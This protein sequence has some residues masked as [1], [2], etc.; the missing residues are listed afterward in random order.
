MTSPASEPIAIVGLACRYPDS[1]SPVEFWENILARR[2]QFRALPPQ[3]LSLEHYYHPD[4]AEPD[5]TYGRKAAVIDGFEFDWASRR[6][7][8]STFLATDIAHWLA[9][10]TAIGAVADAGYTRETIP[11]AATGVIV[12]NS[13]TGEQSR[14]GTMRLRWPYVRRAFLAA[15]KS[16]GLGAEE[17]ERLE[18]AMAHHFKSVFP[19]ANEDM[20]A[21]GLSNTISGRICNFLNLDGGGYTVDGACSSSLLAI[22]IAASGL[23]NRE[24]DLALAGGVDISL[25]SFEL[26]GF[27]K[28]RAL[29]ATDM[30]VYDR[31]GSGFI[32]GEGCGFIV[33]KR[34]SDARRNGDYVY[35]LLQGWGISSDGA[36]TG[37]TAP[38]ADGQKKALLRAYRRA[39]Y[40]IRDLD[41]VEGHGTATPVGDRT[42]LDALSQALGRNGQRGKNPNAKRNGCGITSLKSIVGHTKA[43]AGIG[44]MI[45]TILA[46]NRRVLPPTAACHTPHALFDTDAAGLYPIR[47]GDIRPAGDTIRAG[48]SAMGFGG[49]NC[50]ITV[51]SCDP[52]RPQLHPSVEERAL[53]VSNQDTE[54]FVLA[55]ASWGD[56]KEKAAALQV[57][58]GGISHA[59][60]VDLAA[61]LG[62]E[63]DGPAEYRAALIADQPDQ[64]ANNLAQL[65]NLLNTPPADG[66]CH[67]TPD[68]QLWLGRPV[69]SPRFGM[70]FPGQGSQQLN[71]ARTLTQRYPWARKIVELADQCMAEMGRPPVGPSIF[72]SLDRAKR[73]AA[74]ASPPADLSRTDMAQPAI[75]TA[76]V[77]WLTYLNNLG[78]RAHAVGGHSLGELTAFHAAGVLD[79]RAVIRLAAF[80]GTA[81]ASGRA[82]SG[83]MISL[84]CTREEAQ[85]IVQQ[86]TG[87]LVL[88]NLN[89]PRQMVLSGDAGAVARAAELAAARE[90]RTR[91]LPVSGAFHSRLAAGAA[92]TLRHYPPLATTMPAP[93][94]ALFS[95]M[96][97]ARLEAGV[98]LADHFS[99][100]MLA[101]VDFM[102]L[103]A[104]MSEACDLLFEVGPGRIL[105]GLVRDNA[106]ARATPICLPVESSPSRDRDLNTLI[107]AAFTH[108]ADINWDAL[109][110]KRM[111]RP[112][113]SPSKKQFII[114]PCEKP[115]GDE[116]PV[117]RAA[118]A[119]LSDLPGIP[120]DTLKNY[121]KTRGAFL[122]DVIRADL[123]HGF[124]ASVPAAPGGESPPAPPPVLPPAGSPVRGGSKAAPPSG[125]DSESPLDSV[126]FGLIEK[127]TGFPRES[128]D[129]EMRLLDDLNLDSIK[130]GDLLA[131]AARAMGRAGQLEPMDLANATL[132]EIRDVLARPPE[133]VATMPRILETLKTTVETVTGYDAAALDP[134]A[135]VEDDLNI[136]PE[137]LEKVIRQA[138]AEL[139]IDAQVDLE[140]LLG[141]SLVHIAQILERVSME[142]MARRAELA[143]G[144]ASDWVREFE[145]ERVEAPLGPPSPVAGRRR[146]DNWQFGRVLLVHTPDNDELVDRMQK[147]LLGLGAQ[148]DATSFETARD[149]QTT[150]NGAY[151]HLLA[152]LPR[153][154]DEADL[155][156]MAFQGMV[157]R[158]SAVATPPPASQSL[159]RRTTVAYLQFGGGYFGDHPDH[160]H[161][162]RCGAV[163][164]ASSLHHERQDL[165]VRVLDFSTAIDEETVSELAIRELNTP[166][167][168]VAAGFDHERK[169]RVSR[170]R[171]S[172]PATW[173]P[174]PIS[175]SPADVILV[176]GGAKGITAACALGLAA[177]TN[178]RM[179]LLGRTEMP[180]GRPG[181]PAGT[182]IA[183]TLRKFE[184]RGRVARYYT[185]DVVDRGSLEDAIH[186]IEADLG[187]ITGVIH[188]AG[189]NQPRPI[190]DVSRDMALK[191]IAPKLAGLWN[192]IGAL[193]HAPLKLAVGMSSIIGITGMPG[194][195][196]YGFSNEALNVILHRWRKERPGLHT[197]AV[198]YSIWRDEG[199]GARMG[200]VAQLKRMGTDAI[201]SRD[202][203]E[204]FV[205]LVQK[206]PGTQQVIVTARL[207]GL[208]TW[209]PRALPQTI[210]GRYLETLVQGTP[211]VE[212]VFRTHL[213]LDR[214]PY[215]REHL[216]NGTYLLPTVFGLEAMAQAAAHACGLPV[217]GRIRIEDIQLERPI[218]VDAETGA[219][220]II[221][222]VVGEAST[223]SAIRRIRTG[224]SKYQTGMAGDYFSAVF[225]LGLTEPAESGTPEPAEEAAA[226][227]GLDPAVDLY[228]GKLLFQG[229]MF[230]RIERIFSIETH[231]TAGGRACGRARLT[232]RID[233]REENSATAFPADTHRELLLGD[234]FFR[235]SLLQ[236]A[237]LLVPEKTCLPVRIGRLDI[238]PDTEIIHD[239]RTAARVS[240]QLENLPENT[241][242]EEIDYTLTAVDDDGRVIEKLAGYTLKILKEND[243]FPRAADLVDPEERDNRLLMNALE[244]P[245]QA[246][247]IDVPVA[248]LCPMPGIHALPRPA[249]HCKE[250]P[251]IARTLRVAVPDAFIS[252]K[253]SDM[254]IQWRE[255]GK[256]VAAGLQEHGWDLSLSHDER[257]CLCVA[258]NGPQ[259]CDLAPVTRRTRRDWLDLL[260][261]SREEL[262]DQLLDA[263]EHL[264]RA[265]TRIWSAAEALRKARPDIRARFRIEKTNGEA[266][267]F[268]V[269]GEEK[270]LVLS[271]PLHLT[272]GPERI[273]ALAVRPADTEG[274][275]SIPA[276]ET[277]Y[278]DILGMEHV[279]MSLDGPQGQGVFIQRFH[280]GFRPAAQLSR[281]VYFSN[282]PFWMGE[283]REAS[284]W[285]VLGTVGRDFSAGKYGQVTN[286]THLEI[287]GEATVKDRIEIKLWAS[288][289]RGPANSTMELTFDVRKILKNGGLERLAVCTQNTTWVRILGHGLV[290]PAPYPEYYQKFMD[291][292]HVRLLPRQQAPNRLDSLAEPLRKLHQHPET[293]LIYSAPEGPTVRP[294]IHEQ[295][296]ETSLD[297]ANLVGN[298]YFANYFAWQGQARDHFF[299]TRVPEC[300]RGM[301]EKG[302]LLCLES[303]V[304]HLREAM[305]FDR[306]VVTM[307]LKTLGRFSAVFHFDYYRLDPDNARTKLAVGRQHAIWVERDESGAP[308]PRTFPEAVTRVLPGWKEEKEANSRQIAKKIL[309]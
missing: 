140:P 124:G 91:P 131:Q 146:E 281:N 122:A 226:A 119:Q 136:G 309:K 24:L 273:L 193:A 217:D 2:R 298:I 37:I 17:R 243:G 204:R 137:K 145:V 54:V 29:T 134:D 19:P 129:G 185:C 222:A 302:E 76:S 25:D 297:N 113:T 121:L 166:E 106:G 65:I 93:A 42:E 115:F 72:Q 198:A 84:A 147:Y 153:Y 60:L 114:N 47:H 267:L 57:D 301:G 150:Q 278:E 133:D 165:R 80:R 88:A 68:Q 45:K 96:G 181:D 82:N 233:S 266:V 20:L 44:G 5:K 247:S 31:R 294:V 22:A 123:H 79:T 246:F 67:G 63:A 196:W 195:A 265:G 163:A 192:L 1:R 141:S 187:P 175:W 307:A 170:H 30:T 177:A 101:Q 304:E 8:H 56:L 126:L 117:I 148:V 206:D 199:M 138:S 162:D 271:L 213:S 169:R 303:R 3:R 28:T 221:R 70:L 36:G 200:S 287:F 110:E 282:Y 12:G 13:L 34:L 262:L 109:Y 102:A 231:E 209:R 280:V 164:L 71:M 270:P 182:E 73:G 256:P 23:V 103:L 201:A 211:G 274:T 81:M 130:A 83:A 98:G 205:R 4:P 38:S 210:R 190:A 180:G 293:D 186:T 15:A 99:K 104:A 18:S 308:I 41:F 89:S 224:I 35:A 232:T 97:G 161:M 171:L 144:H 85:T 116:M 207:G 92:K 108:G 305:P 235:D 26:I 257:L 50:H 112:Y 128:L 61:G 174:R 295:T 249:R 107:A 43:A 33:M 253:E 216:F 176:T 59:E 250:R 268:R 238:Y 245:C 191:E 58:A 173:T 228:T 11:G 285:P 32:P 16:N 258:G 284:V 159:R 178:V 152:L 276:G 255:D 223:T 234:P 189:L 120:S 143:G 264:D 248:R 168:F 157:N 172:H 299:H 6:I 283:V 208:D 300:F 227:P 27:A 14:A 10:E 155:S 212:S 94:M 74:P 48:V 194:N 127:M 111:V 183:E 87:Y 236:S 64:L 306:I 21:G 240:V 9:L 290:E 184:E 203:V 225:V 241:R 51:E 259:G 78:I 66:A 254:D 154:S 229:P 252:D 237:L 288:D 158:L 142:Q 105:T 7:P 291:S 202:G 151:T 289:N 275:T 292:P 215:V 251:F 214:D 160:C 279:G 132:A 49:I 46:V 242:D 86:V 135:I 95:G 118:Q 179:A 90:I 272:W 156:P 69:R 188:G 53:L 296:I 218:T 40:D 167:A 239:G 260:G 261:P 77:L 55:G 39:P 263:G 286:D 197:L 220:I 269:P 139:N 62:R 125:Q 52:P 277:G 75:C 219:D 244:P 149:T 230:Q 100:Q